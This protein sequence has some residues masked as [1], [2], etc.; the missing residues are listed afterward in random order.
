MIL[1]EEAQH[2]VRSPEWTWYILFY[3]FLAGLSGGSY[4]LGT[5]LRLRGDEPAA[6][7]GFY[8]ALPPMLISPLLLALDLGKPLR[9][10]HM[11]WNT[12]PGDAGINFKYWSPLS[13]GA[14]ALVVF[15]AFATV[16]FVDT[17]ARDGKLPLRFLVRLLEI[18]R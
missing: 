17:L 15:G 1:A 14:W 13:V 16:S 7:L 6:R 2:F 18:G 5:L 9:F 10:W 8:V 11:L 4:V 12:T 3:F